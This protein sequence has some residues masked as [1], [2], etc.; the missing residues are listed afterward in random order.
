MINEVSQA[1][2][3]LVVIVNS[4]VNEFLQVLQARLCFVS[5]FRLQSVFVTTIQN[6]SLDD[7]GYG[8]GD[9]ETR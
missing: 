7:V 2:D 9:G 8:L 1:G 5:A 4:G 6:C 3:A